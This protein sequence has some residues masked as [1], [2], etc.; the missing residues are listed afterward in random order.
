M[1]RA[2]TYLFAVVPL[3]LTFIF[4]NTCPGNRDGFVLSLQIGNVSVT[5]SS[6]SH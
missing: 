6:C 2:P 5:A 1:H 4:V 3:L